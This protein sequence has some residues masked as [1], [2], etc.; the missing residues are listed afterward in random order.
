MKRTQLA[1]LLFAGLT[2]AGLM[3]APFQNGSFEVGT[4]ANPSGFDTL[5]TGST[6]ITGWTVVG[7]GIDYIGGTWVAASGSRSLDMLS[8][9][10]SGGVAQTFDTVPGATYMV[11]FS[12]AGNPDGGVK[13]LTATAGTTTANFTFNTAGATSAAMNWTARNFVFTASSTSTTL[14][15]R[16]GV[17]GGT[18]SCAGSALDN[19][20]VTL[21]AANTPVPVDG[22]ALGAALLAMVGLAALRR[23]QRA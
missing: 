20:S 7:D 4:L 9:G 2:A 8:C 19:V 18:S 11:S 3:A 1:A 21:L 14:T 22:G 6:A 5:A 10:V 15:M 13:T 23:R 16:G 17:V 12:L